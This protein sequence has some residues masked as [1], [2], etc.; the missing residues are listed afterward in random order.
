MIRTFCFQCGGYRDASGCS[1]CD[2]FKKEQNKKYN[3]WLADECRD[4]IEKIDVLEEA[5]VESER[6]LL[7]L[8]K[9]YEAL[10]WMTRTQNGQRTE[11]P[12]P[13]GEVEKR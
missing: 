2:N 6:D 10:L 1:Y 13:E 3:M 11:T 7:N 9:R 4:L 5:L 8:E 12:T